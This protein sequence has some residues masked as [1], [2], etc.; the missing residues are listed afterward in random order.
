MAHEFNRFFDKGDPKLLEFRMN[1]IEE[2]GGDKLDADV[3]YSY[4]E[5]MNKYSN[6]DRVEDIFRYTKKKWMLTS[7]DHIDT[8]MID[9][10]ISCMSGAVIYKSWIKGAVY[11]FNLRRYSVYNRTLFFRDDGMFDRL[12]EYATMKGLNGVFI[13][14]YPHNQKLRYLTNRLI[15]GKSIPT[16]GNLSK[17]RDM[18]Y[19]GDRNINGVMQ[20][21]F[22]YPITAEFDDTVLM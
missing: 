6:N 22:V 3:E 7:F 21:V 1:V 12:V 8:Y 4:S 11:H 9:G 13:S 18:R 20:S 17:I 14:I 5:I 16:T 19:H 2:C 10:Q 15:Y